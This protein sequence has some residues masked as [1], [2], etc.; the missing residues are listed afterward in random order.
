MTQSL[1]IFSIYNYYIYYNKNGD[2]MN[3][4]IISGILTLLSLTLISTG[5]FL[6][7]IE[8]FDD[9]F[10]NTSEIN[11]K[12]SMEYSQIT[13]DMNNLNTDMKKMKSFFSLYYEE[14]NK[15]KEYYT[16]VLN[17]IKNTKNNLDKKINTTMEMCKKTINKDSKN[18]CDS[19]NK[20]IEKI[21][22][23][24]DNLNNKYDKFIKN[25]EEWLLAFEN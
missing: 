23:N 24:Y 22:K 2:N 13:S 25:H 18:I 8:G 6:N 7:V 21:N 9:D 10:N 3:Y 15:N 19:I 12:I 1:I 20:N 17:E 16:N 14:V 5:C 11:K 4:K